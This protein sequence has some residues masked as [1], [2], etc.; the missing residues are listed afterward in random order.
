MKTKLPLLHLFWLFLLTIGVVVFFFQTK[1]NIET[2]AKLQV[3]VN[4]QTANDKKLSDLAALMPTLSKETIS[5]LKTLPTNEVE[6]ANFATQVE[7][8]AKEQGLLIA[9]NFED[10]PRQIEVSG[11][12]AFGLGTEI[13]L[14]GS[15]QNLTVFLTRISS[16]PYFFKIDKMTILKNETKLGVKA[17]IDGSLIMNLDRN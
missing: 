6:V 2:A 1:F 5:Y 4:N 7:L 10:F 15:F 14:E 9:F 3:E 11:K 12:N 16:L 17:I 8:I 13:S